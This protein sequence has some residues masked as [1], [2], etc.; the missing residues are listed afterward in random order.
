MIATKTS[1]E[2]QNSPR[3][4]YQDK[5]RERAGEPV[6]DIPDAR[7]LQF[8]DARALMREFHEKWGVR[9]AA[10][11]LPMTSP[12]GVN[13]EY[14]TCSLP[15]SR[16][17]RSF[18]LAQSVTE[19][20][21]E[22]LDIYLLI[23][24]TL[25][26]VNVDQLQVVDSKGA[27]SAKLCVGK[28]G[29]QELVGIT[30]AD[31]LNL[32]RHATTS[33]G[34]V[35]GVVCDLTNLWPMGADQSRLELCCFCASCLAE[36]A[37]HG[38]E[39]VT[40]AFLTHPNPWN[41]ALAE[42][43]NQDGISYID[44]LTSVMTARQIVGFSK[45]R[46]FIKVF[47]DITP[48]RQDELAD[49]LMQYL[50]A[51]HNETVLALNAIRNVAK[52]QMGADAADFRW[53][54]LTEGEHYCWTSGLFLDL[55]DDWASYL[56]ERPADEMWFNPSSANVTMRSMAYR[57]YMWSRSRYIIDSFF[58]FATAISDPLRRA[59][60]GIGRL[61]EM[62]ALQMLDSRLQ[63]ALGGE[64]AGLPSLIALSGRTDGDVGR[65]GF[66]GVE[67]SPDV[68]RQIIQSVDVAPEYRA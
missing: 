12:D 9:P 24:P 60:T 52:E 58:Q 45:L 51:R 4:S 49:Q 44:D 22:G 27:S 25:E 63:R 35:R 11:C 16:V 68:G 15:K 48:P 19:F 56:K 50:K 40:S 57:S 43:E 46:G 1:G 42:N 10:V 18:D 8:R 67:L 64:M 13:L 20:T 21:K 6:L 3:T 66:V 55:L 37:R 34:R 61:P 36:L 30:I 28:E 54:L 33:P 47:G 38:A 41:L 65:I 2:S 17:L 14:S 31:A 7:I 39:D 62:M 5:I 29:T 53:V 59:T 32:A 23:E 26:F